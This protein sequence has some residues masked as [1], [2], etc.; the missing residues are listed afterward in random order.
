VRQACQGQSPSER[1]AALT[2]VADK[3]RGTAWRS[4]TAAEV[5]AITVQGAAVDGN[6]YVFGEIINS[7]SDVVV[8]SVTLRVGSSAH[9]QVIPIPP[10]LPAPLYFF[11]GSGARS[12]DPVVITKA[13]GSALG[14][15]RS[16]AAE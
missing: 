7:N 5:A 1:A 4:L 15:A 16:S 6:G 2:P 9:V 12:T 14:T 3:S 10:G 13:M 8:Q 11:A